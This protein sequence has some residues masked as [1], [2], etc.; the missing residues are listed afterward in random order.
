LLVRSDLHPEIVQLLLQTMAAKTA[1][2]PP[3]LIAQIGGGDLNAGRRV[4]HKLVS[5]VRSQRAKTR[6]A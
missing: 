2:V 4:L 1:T 3:E 6:A 5:M